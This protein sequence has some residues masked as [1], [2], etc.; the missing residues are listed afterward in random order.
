METDDRMMEA[1]RQRKDLPPAHI[2]LRKLLAC[3]DME[4]YLDLCSNRLA[5]EEM[6]D[7][8]NTD[9]NFSDFPDLLFNS[10]G[11]FECRH[12]LE[13][14]LTDDIL[15]DAWKMLLDAE[16]KDNEINSIAAAFRKMRLRDL[17]KCYKEI[18]P[19]EAGQ[20]VRKWIAAEVWSRSFFSSF[21]RKAEEGLR[22]VYVN[23]KYKRLFDMIKTVA[24]S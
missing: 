3:G 2:S 9:I 14:Y 10:K 7:G 12:I 8:E 15:A 5:E 19:D 24:G 17:W 16:R 13:N 18:K 4:H 23:V 21:W 22:H 1:I 11:L 20:L 6:I